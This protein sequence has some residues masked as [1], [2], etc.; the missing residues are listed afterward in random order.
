MS[1]IY[2]FYPSTNLNKI[3]FVFLLFN[4]YHYDYYNIT[5]MYWQDRHSQY[6]YADNLLRYSNECFTFYH[7]DKIYIRKRK[8]SSGK[9]KKFMTLESLLFYK[10]NGR[11]L[12]LVT[13]FGCY[14]QKSLHSSKNVTQ[15][16]IHKDYSL[17]HYFHELHMLYK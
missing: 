17:Y 8:T 4:S 5:F 10:L 3:M 14:D 2:E 13:T 12:E 6:V 9:T 11:I 15:V 7:L 1:K 16:F